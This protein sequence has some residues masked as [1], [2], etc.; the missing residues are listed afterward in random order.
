MRGMSPDTDVGEA[1]TAC[2]SALETLFYGYSQ[3]NACVVTP[4]TSAGDA[5]RASSERNGVPSGRQT[6][7]PW[8]SRNTDE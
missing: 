4:S 7:R 2:G 5:G 6:E 3:A 1:I 8:M